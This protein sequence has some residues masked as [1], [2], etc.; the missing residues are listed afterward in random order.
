[1]IISIHTILG[2]HHIGITTI[3]GGIQAFTGAHG[4]ILI[5]IW[6]MVGAPAGVGI[7]VGAGSTVGG[8]LGV[9]QSV[10]ADITTIIHVIPEHSATVLTASGHKLQA[11]D[12]LLTEAGTT[13]LT[14][15]S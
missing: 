15:T 11:F 1:M 8:L 13:V 5:G 6:L 3:G 10:A 12:L 4:M 2:T 7:T 14:E 9:V